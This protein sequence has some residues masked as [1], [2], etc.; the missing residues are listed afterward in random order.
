MQKLL[1][2]L[3]LSLVVT[4]VSAQWVFVGENMSR[5]K[6]YVDPATK[7]RTGNVV[8]MWVLTDYAKSG[9][10]DGK[11]SFSD[12]AYTQYDCFERTSQILQLAFFSGKMLNG[13]LLGSD[14]RLRSKDFIAPGTMAEA[15]L[16]F[17]CK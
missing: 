9:V 8:R 11:V 5:D 2:G 1:V 13:Q 3:S 17:A 7:R 16:N 4:S 12:R 6:S 10:I 15:Q 14:T